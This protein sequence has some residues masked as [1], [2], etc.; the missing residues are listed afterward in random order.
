MC[1]GSTASGTWGPIGD[2]L[3]CDTAAHQPPSTLT[4]HCLCELEC[5][6]DCG[7][8]ALPPGHLL[9]ECVLKQIYK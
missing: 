8:H 5:P 1:G 9:G 3:P 7:A 2:A 4:N 6:A